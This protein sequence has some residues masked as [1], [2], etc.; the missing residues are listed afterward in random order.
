MPPV[1]PEVIQIIPILG[2]GLFYLKTLNR[3]YSE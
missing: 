3:V 1:A 2:I